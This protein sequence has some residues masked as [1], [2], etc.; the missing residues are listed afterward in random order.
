MGVPLLADRHI[1]NVSRRALAYPFVAFVVFYGRQWSDM[2]ASDNS[3]EHSRRDFGGTL[4]AHPFFNEFVSDFIEND[5]VAARGLV[6]SL[7][8]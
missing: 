4:R 2:E 6:L 1:E 7:S 3:R 8:I 5:N